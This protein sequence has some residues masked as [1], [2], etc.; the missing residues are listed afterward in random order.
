MHQTFIEFQGWSKGHKGQGTMIPI[1]LTHAFPHT[2]LLP[3]KNV[4]SKEQKKKKEKSMIDSLTGQV[5]SAM[6]SPFS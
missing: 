5:D 3:L 1:E 2:R 6:K 4:K